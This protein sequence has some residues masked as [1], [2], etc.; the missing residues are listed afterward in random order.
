MVPPHLVPD[1]C[2][3]GPA[4]DPQA[5]AAVAAAARPG[6]PTTGTPDSVEE[7]PRAG[8]LDGARGDGPSN[9]LTPQS[10]DLRRAS[11]AGPP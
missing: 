7:I 11:A 1:L 10:G 8:L 6:V 3:W 4:A 5:R 2:G 9:R